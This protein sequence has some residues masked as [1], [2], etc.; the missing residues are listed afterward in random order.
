MTPITLNLKANRRNLSAAT[1]KNNNYDDSRCETKEVPVTVEIDRAKDIVR[2][3]EGGVTGYESFHISDVL[4]HEPQSG[5]YWCAGTPGRWDSL[6]MP[7]PA[8]E[9]LLA[10]LRSDAPRLSSPT[11][12]P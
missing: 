9:I 8:V 11:V 10:A 2:I 3:S 5:M 4:R 7:Q 1:W 12:M 6:F